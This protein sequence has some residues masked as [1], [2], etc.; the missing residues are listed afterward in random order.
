MLHV[1]RD[2]SFGKMHVSAIEVY[3]DVAYD[4]LD[5]RKLLR[6]GGT[7]SNA[8]VEY[9][10]T[11]KQKQQDGSVKIVQQAHPST[12]DCF[13]CF[14]MKSQPQKS[15]SN[16]NSTNSERNSSSGEKFTTSGET[17]WPITKPEDVAKL[18]RTI[19]MTR[20]AQG[21]LLNDRSSRSHCLVSLYM[22]SKNA[23][24]VKETQFLFV[25]LAGSERIEKSGVTG[26]RATE[27][28]CINSSLTT[29]GR[30]IK[31]KY[32]IKYSMI[33]LIFNYC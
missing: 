25:D 31:V 1:L 20:T 27:A 29:L 22:T 28:T 19:E 32:F 13:K 23:S 30:V 33:K 3:L 15:S 11:T 9:I 21:H 14:Q 26:D 7:R 16:T 2:G 10:H 12:C 8:P 18:A 6:V 24:T 17:R 5:N 4:L